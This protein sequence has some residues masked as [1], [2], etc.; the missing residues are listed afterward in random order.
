MSVASRDLWQRRLLGFQGIYYLAAGLWPIV[1]MSS[2]ERVTGAKVDDWL[3]R[4]VG[5]LAAVIGATLVI[6][7]RRLRSQP[8]E[9]IVL[10]VGS[11][12]AF[13]LIDMWYGL[14]G[15]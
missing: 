5:L 6:A 9:T 2:F 10:A 11:A 12:L 8:V 15:R 3:V 4:M 7:V 1:S 14:T 13:T